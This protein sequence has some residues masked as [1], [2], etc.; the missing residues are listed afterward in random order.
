[1]TYIL[2]GIRGAMLDGK[3]VFDMSAELWKLLAVSLI[4]L[5]LGVWIFQKAVDYAKRTGRLKRYG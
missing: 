4:S 1:A 5:P 2:E 3:S